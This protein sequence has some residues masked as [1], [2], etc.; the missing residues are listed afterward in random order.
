MPA[1]APEWSIEFIGDARSEAEEIAQELGSAGVPVGGP[2]R[3]PDTDAELG[4]AELILTAIASVLLESVL[5][6]AITRI[7]HYVV[8]RVKKLR[9]KQE[10]PEAFDLQV[11]VKAEKAERGHRESLALT[12]AT[13]EDIQAFIESV[14]QAI[15]RTIEAERS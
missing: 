13:P 15:L 3:L 10:S 12:S 6:V 5:D 11:V 1:T 8:T 9:E 4:G 7:E 2:R 14:K